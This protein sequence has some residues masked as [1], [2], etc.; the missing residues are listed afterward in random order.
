MIN[1]GPARIAGELRY[2]EGHGWMLDNVSGRYSLLNHDMRF[3]H[4]ENAAAVF[5]RAGLRLRT[6]FHEPPRR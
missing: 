6:T 4:L 3:E 5:E 2:V 1:G